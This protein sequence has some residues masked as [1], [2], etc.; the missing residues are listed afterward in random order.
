[1]N[2]FA[3][4]VAASTNSQKTFSLFDNYNIPDL[5]SNRECLQ[6]I[7]TI[8]SNRSDARRPKLSKDGREIVHHEQVSSKTS[9]VESPSGQ[10]RTHHLT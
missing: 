9:S 4:L 8:K 2:S 6:I 7:T 3:L 1:M 5:S 10:K